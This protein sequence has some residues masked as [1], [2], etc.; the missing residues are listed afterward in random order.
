MKRSGSGRSLIDSVGE[1]SAEHGGE[2]WENWKMASVYPWPSLLPVSFCS[3]RNQVKHSGGWVRQG[4][5]KRPTCLENSR[6]PVSRCKL[7]RVVTQVPSGHWSKLP[8]WWRQNICQNEC[9]LTGGL[10]E[11][12]RL[13]WSPNQP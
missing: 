12:L 11:P 9:Q 1:N 10:L 3:N 2:C 13:G 8:S 5:E 7:H 6:Q 4:I